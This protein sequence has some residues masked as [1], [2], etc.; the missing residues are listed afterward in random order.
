MSK[1]ADHSIL[2]VCTGNVCRSP[3]AESLLRALAPSGVSWQI[4]SA[5]IAAENGA[6][7]SRNAVDV[8]AELGADLRSHRSSRLTAELVDRAYIIVG[9]TQAHK[10][11]IISAFPVAA[12]KVYLLKSFDASGRDGDVADPIGG[13]T[14]VYRQTR[15]EIDRALAPLVDFLKTNLG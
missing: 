2:F 5:G 7:A 12:D 14:D 13:S 1:V 9:M 8:M 15:D 10:Q 6:S 4:A 11:A 3:M